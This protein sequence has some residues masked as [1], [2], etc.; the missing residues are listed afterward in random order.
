MDREFGR[1]DYEPDD[2]GTFDSG[3]V[4]V[5][6]PFMST[7]SADVYATIREACMHVG[8][9]ATRVDET[10]GSGFIIKEVSDLIERA[11]FIVCDL[12]YE[13]P[14]VYYELGYAHGVGNEADDILLIAKAGTKLHFDIAPLRVHYFED[15][16]ALQSIVEKQVSRM[17]RVTR[18]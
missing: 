3:L 7:D 18:R 12:S 6:M 10:G 8:L 1:Q 14:N 2:A 15:L 11:E 9:R 13:R 16:A 17:I 4:F 5:M